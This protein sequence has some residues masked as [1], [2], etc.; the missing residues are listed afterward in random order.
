MTDRPIENLPLRDLIQGAQ[1]FSRELEEHLD[2]GFL[3]KVEKLEAAIRPADQE[4]VP[5]TDMTVRRQVQEILDS[6]KFAD[7]LMAKVENYLKAIDSSLQQNVLN[8]S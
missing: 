4:K 2:Q 5:I 8:Q 7:Q 6:H 1:Q 3:P